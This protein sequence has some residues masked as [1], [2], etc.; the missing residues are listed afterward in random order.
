MEEKVYE[1]DILEHVNDL[2]TREAFSSRYADAFSNMF[3]AYGSNWNMPTRHLIPKDKSRTKMREIFIFPDIDSHLMKHMSNVLTDKFDHLIHPNVFSYR[4][5]L[6][7][8]D[9]CTHIVSDIKEKYGF[10]V[11]ITDY[12]GSADRD[13]IKEKINS[14]PLT[15][16]S[17]LLITSVFDLN[18]YIERSTGEVITRD[19]GLMQGSA[20]SGFV[21]NLFL[22][23]VD[24]MMSSKC[25]RYA[26]YSDDMI[27]LFNTE[28]EMQIGL[29]SLT[30]ALDELGLSLNPKKTIF[31]K[32]N[33]IITFLGLDIYPATGTIDISEK[34]FKELK[35]SIKATCKRALT[36][37]KSASLKC[38]VDSI[39]QSLYGISSARTSKFGSAVSLFQNVNTDET[40]KKL[41]IYIVDT[42]RATM[43]GR[44]NSANKLKYPIPALRDAG[45]LSMYEMFHTYLREPETYY[46]IVCNLNKLKLPILPFP[47]F[48]GKSLED[49][50][51]SFLQCLFVEP[52][53][54]KTAIATKSALTTVAPELDEFRNFRVER[55]TKLIVLHKIHEHILA[56]QSPNLNVFGKNFFVYGDIGIKMCIPFW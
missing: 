51:T 47:H 5:N 45:L 22:Y 7:R 19:M 16:E 15:E 12:F 33:E 56:T 52:E 46:S 8:L 48:D 25:A 30:G 37:K 1:I 44:Y 24:A 50:Y 36:K 26:R 31:Y 42:V 53:F 18:Q 55:N 9:A 17:K 10:K 6:K 49:I 34:N 29:S 41:D 54:N 38:V 23:E 3:F 40:I 20:L 21:S 39:N 35:M 2:K 27:C 43:T 32:P 14:L 13:K 28:E 4:R 11:D